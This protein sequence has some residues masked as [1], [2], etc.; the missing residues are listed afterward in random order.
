[1]IIPRKADSKDFA[2]HIQQLANSRPARC[3]PWWPNFLFHYTDLDNAVS[4]LET[5]RIYSRA[6]AIRHG[7]MKHD[8]ASQEVIAR[9]NVNI[10]E[11]A[12]CYF[13]PRT[14]TQYNNEGIR[15]KPDLAMTSCCPVPIFFLLDAVD[16]LTRIDTRFCD[17]NA[18][19]T[20]CL[21][22]SAEEF[23]RM[24]F[25]LI[26]HD[27]SFSPDRRDSIV[28]HRQAEVLIPDFLEV[29]ESNLHYI[30]CRS[31]AEQTTLLTSLNQEALQYWR[32]RILCNP[33]LKLFFGKWTYVIEASLDVEQI[34]LK[35]NVSSDSKK[36][37][38]IRL[39][40][41]EVATGQTY[42]WQENDSH[43]IDTDGELSIDL[44]NLSY[45]EQYRCTLFLDD[46]VAFH[47]ERIE[48]SDLPF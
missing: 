13:R 32:P 14:P 3:E 2:K 5:H 21:F 9:T 38:H 43:L 26:Y 34:L 15:A 42:L 46:S 37:F 23:A 28:R 7:L 11:Y 1:M 25:D 29:H 41:I 22:S 48:G 18:Y 30:I 19:Y 12:R 20:Q 35:F 47:G 17:G 45:P 36:P 6:S 31:P 44:S 33:R 39:E 24:P 16:V 4:I 27:T 10:T 8:N 40:I